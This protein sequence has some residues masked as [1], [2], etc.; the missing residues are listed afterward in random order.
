MLALLPMQLRWWLLPMPLRM[1]IASGMGYALIWHS[2]CH[3]GVRWCSEGIFLLSFV[4]KKNLLFQ[5]P[6]KQIFIN[7]FSESFTGVFT[8]FQN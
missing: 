6:S 5:K 3:I 4:L 7:T 2:P 8:Q 1:L